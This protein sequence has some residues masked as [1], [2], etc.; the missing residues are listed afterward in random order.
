VRSYYAMMHV[1]KHSLTSLQLKIEGRSVWIDYW[2]NSS[3]KRNPRVRFAK[4]G[5][6][7]YINVCERTR[8][9]RS[10]LMSAVAIAMLS[11]SGT[12]TMT[13]HTRASNGFAHLSGR[14][15]ISWTAR[16]RERAA[17][18]KTWRI[19]SVAWGAECRCRGLSSDLMYTISDD[20]N[21]N[22]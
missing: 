2:R 7:Y 22:S 10:S 18:A 11:R 17:V 5:D 1:W 12:V 13:I 4:L 19:A 16:I 21:T 9:P 20:R 14:I 3:K 8:F 15:W 6:I